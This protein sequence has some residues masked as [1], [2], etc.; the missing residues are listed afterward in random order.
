M[1]IAQSA[2]AGRTITSLLVTAGMVVTVGTALAFQH[3]GGY[4]PCALCLEQRD[5]Y[6]YSIPLGILAVAASLLKLPA[7][8]TRSLLLVIG[9]AMLIGAG[10]G[11]YHAGVEWAFWAG[12]TTCATS[13]PSITTNAGNLLGDLN[14]I[15][16]PSCSEASLRVLGLSFAG[17]NVLAS[18]TLAAIAFYGASRKQA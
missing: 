11:V 16:A 8:T 17:W 2:A 1:A 7:W 18:L 13:A 10:L 5:P 9:V 3:I 15:K 6:Y 12:P 14:A 4:T